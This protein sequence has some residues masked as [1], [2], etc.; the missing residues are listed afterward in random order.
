LPKA[1]REDELT[2]WVLVFQ[3]SGPEALDYAARKWEKNGS[4]A[5]LVTALAKVHAGHPKATALIEAAAKVKPNSPAF[6]STAYHSLRVM[7]EAGRKDDAR[8]Q[9]D[10]LLAANGS[11]VPSAR[12]H[13]LALRMKV[14]ANLDELLKYSVRV[15]SGV[16]FDED[17]RELPMDKDEGSDEVKNSPR[18]RAAWDVDATRVLNE[19]VPL[20][21]LKEAAN[22]KTLP[23][24][25]RRDLAIATWVRAAL[26]DDG[27]TATTLAPTVIGLAPELRAEIT[28]YV[29]AADAPAKKFAAIYLL[30]KYPGA[31]P[32]VD[33]SMGRLTE[34]GK[35]DDYRD[36]WWC[37]YGQK[38]ATDETTPKKPAEQI[39]PPDFLTAE[40]KAAAVA[41]WKKLV[42]LGTG[43]NYLCAQAVKWATL[44]PTDP[45][46]PEA[47]HLAVRATRYGCT[48][49]QTGRLSKQAYD[50]LHQKY[51]KSEWAQKTKYWFKD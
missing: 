19:T 43:P 23:A 24:H 11:L 7:I 39:G 51:P 38:P 36:N 45:R 8:K 5:W 30:L 12:N 28:A 50:V 41:E 44:K 6:A 21:L 37:A 10:A 40:Q 49:A 15:P 14:A 1:G 3:S 16:S 18:L 42:A 27:Q 20:G 25:L 9:L 46:A 31:R 34:F 29:A 48:D 22:S 2:D 4:L 35:I 17:G 47:L 26:L 32:T 33:A 13:F